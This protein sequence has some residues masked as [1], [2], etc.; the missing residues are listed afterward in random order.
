M[1]TDANEQPTRCDDVFLAAQSLSRS[2]GP[3]TALSGVSVDFAPGEI[4][5]IVGENGAGK[6]TLMR[7]LSGEERADAGGI[8]INGV[9]VRIDSP[10]EARAYGI[11]IVHQSFQ[12]VDTLTVAENICLGQPPV[13]ARIGPI[14]LVDHRRMRRLAE[15]RLERFGLT[16]TAS[17]RVRRSS[18]RGA[19]ACRNR[20]RN[21]SVRETVDSGRTDGVAGCGRNS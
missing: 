10:Q 5:A 13:K 20:A 18:G 12:L 14:A 16:H 1:T 2:Y 4:H 9:P 21:G 15:E 6:S 7:L 3:I 11:A 8:L 17:S 19:P